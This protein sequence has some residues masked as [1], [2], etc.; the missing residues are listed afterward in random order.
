MKEGTFVEGGVWIRRLLFPKC[1]LFRLGVTF[2]TGGT[3]CA[4]PLWYAGAEKTGEGGLL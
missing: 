4:E 2:V 3:V 1:G